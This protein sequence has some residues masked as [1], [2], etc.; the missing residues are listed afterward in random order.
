MGGRDL[1]EIAPEFDATGG[2]DAVDAAPGQDLP[3]VGDEL[4]YSHDTFRDAK[5][6]FSGGFGK[7]MARIDELGGKF[8]DNLPADVKFSGAGDGS[9][10]MN[11][12][13]RLANLRAAP[14]EGSDGLLAA[15]IV[16]D[17]KRD[18]FQEVAQGGRY[19]RR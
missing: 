1:A 3:F 8:V 13:E 16:P 10:G 4:K 18:Y 14:V 6:H 2:P 17:K 15:A 11:P 5:D 12:A 7:G 19:G 9:L